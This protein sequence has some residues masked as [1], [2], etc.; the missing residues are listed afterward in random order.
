MKKLLLFASIVLTLS[1]S[2][3]DNSSSNSSSKITPPAWIQGSYYQ[4][5]EGSDSK[6]GGYRF[7]S[8]DV[9]VLA[10]TSETCMKGA[11]DV[12]RGTDTYT[13]VEQSSTT[14][15]YKCTITIGAQK[16]NYHFQKVSDNTIK[17]VIMSNS[18]GRDALLVKQ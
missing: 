4:V 13:N 9:C 7:Y 6:V 3:D 18:L 15:E 14:T 10:Y 12:Y 5:Y 2:S 17:D 11:I 1:C 16:I 8:D